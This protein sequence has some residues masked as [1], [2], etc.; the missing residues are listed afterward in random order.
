MK[1]EGNIVRFDNPGQQEE[2]ERAMHGAG[3]ARDFA[4]SLLEAIGKAKW[5]ADE[6][7]GMFR[8]ELGDSLAPTEGLIYNW[9]ERELRVSKYAQPWRSDE[10][11]DDDAPSTANTAADKPPVT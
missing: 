11:K 1:R 8:K 2:F 9:P 7:W 4:R 5:E 10:P 3:G 6:W